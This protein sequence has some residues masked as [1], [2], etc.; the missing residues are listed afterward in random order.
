MA[1]LLIQAKQNKSSSFTIPYDRQALADYLGVDRSAM[2]VEISKLRKDGIIACEK[3][4][5]ELL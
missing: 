5:F 3:S 4:H 1:Y 2:A